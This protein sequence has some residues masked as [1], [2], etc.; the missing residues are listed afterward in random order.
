VLIGDAVAAGWQVESQFVAPGGEPVAGADGEVLHLADGV[1]ERVATTVT[2]RPVIAIVRR[3]DHTW[4]EMAT[5][6]RVLVADGV[7]DPGNLGT[8]LR[9]AEA[10]GIDAVAVTPGT[11][12]AY[13]PKTVRASAGAVFNVAIVPLASLADLRPLGLTVFGT[14]SHR[15]RAYTE[16]DLAARVAIVF[17]NEAHGL[18]D[19][20]DVDDWVSIP[21]H[22]RA[23]SLNVAM[24]ATVLCFESARQQHAG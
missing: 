19:D 16:V 22:G 17:G 24:A 11:V 20:A 6:D 10:S 1:I 23:E 5:V 2:P 13:S 3:R 9:S 18:P 14:S 21:H 7:A 12:D 15:G 4:S 8:M